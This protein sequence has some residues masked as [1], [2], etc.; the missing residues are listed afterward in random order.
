LGDALRPGAIADASDDAQLAELRVLGELTERAWKHDVQVMVEGPGT[1][2]L[3]T[4]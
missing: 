4:R 2:A 1:R 3:W